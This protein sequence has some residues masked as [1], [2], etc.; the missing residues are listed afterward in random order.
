MKR[1]FRSILF[2][3]LIS[4]F[5][6]GITVSANDSTDQSQTNEIF[7]Q[8]DIVGNTADALEELFDKESTLDQVNLSYLS[9][10]QSNSTYIIQGQLL[11]DNSS[12]DFESIGNFYKNEKTENSATFENLILGELEDSQNFHFVQ[13]K[14]DR[15]LNCVDLIMQFKDTKRLAQFSFPITENEFTQLYNNIVN[16]LEGVEL[17]KKIVELYSA[18]SN[19]INANTESLESDIQ[20]VQV[21][22]TVSTFSFSGWKK[23]IT[24]LNEKGSVTLSNYSGIK[25][26][27]FKGGGW[28]HENSW[29]TAPYSFSI[30]STANGPDA[31]LSQ[32]TMLDVTKQFYGSGTID[33]VSSLKMARL[34]VNYLDGMVVRYDSITDKLSVMYYN[35]GLRFKNVKLGIRIIPP[36]AFFIDRKISGN[37]EH[38]GNVIR[39]AVALFGTADKIVSIFD[40]LKFHENQEIGKT[41]IFGQDPAEQCKKYDEILHG[42]AAD[43]ENGALI[44]NGHNICLEGQIRY[45]NELIFEPICE[46]EYIAQHNI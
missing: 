14:F 12:I 2:I 46:Y 28:N 38:P 42:I 1:K 25:A 8:E 30:Y 45:L 20:S 18:S 7:S 6:F 34:Q 37:Y 23:L 32:F 15:E 19:L 21:D 3:T 43:T 17:E 4:T 13:L 24:D 44:K 29:S 27:W 31:Y 9:I 40:Y 5:L 39:A 35:Y 26:S 10:R 41:T 16:N 11:Y 33:A 36:E 22:E